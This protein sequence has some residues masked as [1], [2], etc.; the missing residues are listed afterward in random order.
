MSKGGRIALLIGLV[1]FAPPDVAARDAGSLD[2]SVLRAT[3][4]EDFA[5]F[6]ASASGFANGRP[7]WRT[8]YIGGDRTLPNN[9]EVEWYADVGPFR[10]A[11]GILEI[12]ATPE[13]GLSRGLTHRSGLIMSQTLFHQRYGYFE[14][15]AQLPAGKGL[16]PAFWLLPSDGTWPPE[17][18]AMEMLGHAPAAYFVAVHARP[19]GPAVDS[20][21]AVPSPDL[22][23]GFHV[24]GVAWRPNV[25]RF[26]LDGALVHEE[27]TPSDMH[28][29]M[30]LL[31]NLAVGG[32]NSWPGAAAPDQ[33]GVYRIAW[34][35]A[36]QFEDLMI[37][38]P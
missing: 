19:P 30:Y 5:H 8:T 12:A 38:A 33:T 16:W 9:H 2:R 35:R 15:R 28:R 10:V 18:D 20:V 34:I 3:F 17:I 4:A 23:A 26:F 6:S 37:Q 27:A 22:T 32:V 7:V 36:W 29:P 13:P 31:A 24:F 1:S 25:I 21:T 14:I 11:G